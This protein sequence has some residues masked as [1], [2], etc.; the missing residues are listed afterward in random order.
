MS[1]NIC[2]YLYLYVPPTLH[3][4]TPS[5]NQAFWIHSSC[6]PEYSSQ[7]CAYGRR[8]TQVTNGG[9][10]AVQPTLTLI[11]A[12]QWPGFYAPSYTVY[13]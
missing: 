6:S 10:T 9:P 11:P 1:T 7:I 8:V 13:I 4:S 2:I 12:C 3:P 5:P